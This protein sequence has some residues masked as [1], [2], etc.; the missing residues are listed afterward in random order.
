LA[1]VKPDRSNGWLLETAG[2]AASRGLQARG[3]R[4]RAAVRASFPYALKRGINRIAFSLSMPRNCSGVT[5]S[6]C[7]AAAWDP[8]G[9]YG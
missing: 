3:T 1:R 7:K 2:R 5:G 6:F 8:I 4:A 9:K